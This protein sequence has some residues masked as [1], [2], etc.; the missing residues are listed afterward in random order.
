MDMNE[1]NYILNSD[2]NVIAEGEFYTTGRKY[3]VIGPKS[4]F[5]AGYED[6]YKKRTFLV[7]KTSGE[8]VSDLV[9]SVSIGEGLCYVNGCPVRL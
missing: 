2:L 9:Q 6:E 5:L 1:T 4:S 7:D 3:L 8:V